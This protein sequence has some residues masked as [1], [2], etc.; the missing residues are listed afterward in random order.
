MKKEDK[1]KNE[2]LGILSLTFGIIS[3]ISFTLPLGFIAGIISGIL[4]LVFGIMQNKREKSSYAKA[5]IITSVIG[6]ILSGLAFIWFISFVAEI[7]QY[8]GDGQINGLQQQ[9]FSSP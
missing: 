5:G 2:S 9:D 4:G 8:L 1:I 7:M 3:I 6:L